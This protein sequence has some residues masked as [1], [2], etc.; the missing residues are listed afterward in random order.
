MASKPSKLTLIRATKIENGRKYGI[1]QCECGNMKEIRIDTSKHII[2]CG[3]SKKTARINHGHA[4]GTT[5][6]LYSAWKN[7]KA[8]STLSKQLRFYP[9][10]VGVC[11]DPKWDT[12]VGFLTNP[13]NGEFSKG[14]VLSRKDDLGDYT[15]ENCEWKTK[16]ENA[17]ERTDR[18]CIRMPDGSRAI[19]HA[20]PLGLE[21][22]YERRLKKGWKIEDAVSYPKNS[23]SPEYV[24]DQR[25]LRSK[26]KNQ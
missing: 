5:T 1:F 12:F 6:P 11:R 19:D 22:I 15:P 18:T 14:K 17:R 8:R 24:I 23:K 13:P 10:Y 16:S 3:C 2:S 26:I 7:M 20:K 9:S 21:K 4:V 25:T